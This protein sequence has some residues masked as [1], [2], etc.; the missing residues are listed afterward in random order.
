M[1]MELINDTDEPDVKENA[2][3]FPKPGS[4][5]KKYSAAVIVVALMPV[6]GG[7]M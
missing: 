3:P 5:S 7:M 2:V 4:A 1:F 6:T